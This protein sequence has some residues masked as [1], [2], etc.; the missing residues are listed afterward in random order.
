MLSYHWPVFLLTK[1][2]SWCNNSMLSTFPLI[3]S[4]PV[5]ESAILLSTII[6]SSRSA[7]C[8]PPDSLLLSCNPVSAILFLLSVLTT[9][10][11]PEVQLRAVITSLSSWL[12][13]T[14]LWSHSLPS[15]FCCPRDNIL[16]SCDGPILCHH[17]SAVLL[18][19]FCCPPIQCSA[20][21]ILQFTCLYYCTL[22]ISTKYVNLWRLK[23]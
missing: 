10:C 8:C 20:N 18:A 9:F 23:H 5:Q 6:M 21:S 1:I 3:S 4:P 2:S 15:L 11:C 7:F 12:H 17:Y 13:S 19:T 16:L 14:V 22:H